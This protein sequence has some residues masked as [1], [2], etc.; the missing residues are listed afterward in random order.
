VPQEDV[1]IVVVTN[2]CDDAFV[3]AFKDFNH[4]I[5][6]KGV[7]RFVSGVYGASRL[8]YRDLFSNIRCLDIY[9]F[10]LLVYYFQKI[11]VNLKNQ[12]DS[13]PLVEI[14]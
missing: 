7:T 4:L 3:W 12:T 13:F 8:H 11:L 6:S 5:N 10:A 1:V 2:W 14:N 9:E